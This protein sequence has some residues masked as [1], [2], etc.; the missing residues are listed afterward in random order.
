MNDSSRLCSGTITEPRAARQLDSAL[1]A[2]RALG[3]S[4]GEMKRRVMAFEAPYLLW[5]L[6]ECGLA[7]TRED[8]EL[9]FREV[10]RY[11]LLCQHLRRA[12]PMSSSLVDATWHQFVLFTAQYAEFCTTC[13]G[14]FCHHVP[15]LPAAPAAEAEDVS[16][17]DLAELYQAAFGCALPGVWFDAES[18]QPDTRLG[19]RRPADVLSV[20]MDGDRAVLL[21]GEESPEVVCRVSVRGRHALEFLA[22]HPRFMVRELP[23]LSTPAE[24]VALCRP[25]VRYGILRI[26]V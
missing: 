14:A 9:L 13:L 2:A 18:L 10:R 26:A 5:K 19:R 21:R 20:D 24:S 8:A 4:D 17:A 23:G 6:V 15:E 25:L 1:A 3:E 22:A 7:R 11:L 12:L 16:M